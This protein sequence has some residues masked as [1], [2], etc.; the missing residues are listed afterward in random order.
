MVIHYDLWWSIAAQN[1]ATH[2]AH[3]IGQQ[4]CVQV[5]RLIARDTIEERILDLQAK[6]GALMESLM[7]EPEK[8][9]LSMSREELL[10]LL[11]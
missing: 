5:Y 2:R 9:I 6:K 3:R 11:E 10:A 8:S 4:A 1:Q 7:A